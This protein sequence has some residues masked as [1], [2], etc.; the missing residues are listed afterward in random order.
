MI[1]SQ[2]IESIGWKHF[3]TSTNGGSKV[4][5]K[6]DRY[7][8]KSNVDNFIYKKD[9]NEKL[10]EIIIQEVEIKKDV[11]FSRDLG[12]NPIFNEIDLYVGEPVDLEELKE[13]IKKLGI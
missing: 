3:A 9:N 7:I 10:N 12:P 1:T 11:D 5:G 4:F 2:E 8:M 6:D 13:I